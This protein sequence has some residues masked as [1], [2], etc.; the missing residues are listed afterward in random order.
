MSLK[1]K[2]LYV[3]DRLSIAITSIARSGRTLYLG[4][5]AGGQALAAYDIDSGEIKMLPPVFPWIKDR[6]YCTKIHNAL[7]VLADGSL[8]LGEGNHFTWDGIPVTS[9]YFDG[10]LP[11]SMLG[12]KRAQ[13]FPE[14]KYTDFCLKNLDN[15][16]RLRD[17]PGGKIVRF[18]PVARKSEVVAS[19]PTYLYVQSM[20]VDP[21][22]KRAFGHSIP[23]NHFFYFNL[24]TGKVTDHGRISDYAFHNLAVAPNGI[25]YGAWLD[26]ATSELKLLRFDPVTETLDHLEKVILPDIGPK[27]AGNQGIDQWIVTRDGSMY[28]GTVAEASLLR[29]DWEREQFSTVSPRL[30][31]ARV[32]SLD[33]DEDGMIWIGA[34]YPHMQLIRFN[35]HDKTVVNFGRINDSHPRCYFH[36][37]CYFEGK[38]Y[39]GETDGFSPSLHIIDLKQLTNL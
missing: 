37:A 11:E 26:K 20:I 17:N 19:L 13:G 21:L 12:R 6:G 38:L 33:E 23:D 30:A 10:E 15:W 29:F 32:T 3:N 5:T 18:D 27:V 1:V 28:V 39:L 2:E 22:R 35:P 14:V 8:L 25:C 24:N 36:G 9:R 16:N 4:L 34:G 7:G 31:E